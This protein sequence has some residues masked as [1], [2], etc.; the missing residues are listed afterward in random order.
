MSTHNGKRRTSGEI[1]QLI[2][3]PFLSLVAV[4]LLC[5]HWNMDMAL[6]ARLYSPESGWLYRDVPLWR[7][8]YQYG[9]L[10]GYFMVASALIS[11]YS[12]T[13]RKWKKDALFLILL[14][15]LGP[16]L[17]VNL[18]FKDHWGRPRPRQVEAFGGNRSY[19]APW[20]PTF[21]GMCSSF[22]CGHA[23]TAFFIGAPFFPLLR[24][25][26]SLARVFL[27]LGM[28]YGLLMGAAR[29]AQGG[30][31]L[32]DV[33]WAGGMVYLTGAVLYFLM[34]FNVR[35]ATEEACPQGGMA[36]PENPAEPATGVSL[37]GQLQIGDHRPVL[38]RPVRSGP[39][40]SRLQV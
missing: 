35:T 36:Y 38:R 29:M 27:A 16:G 34:G 20:E 13:R 40:F 6:A 4:T 7:C 31:F 17:L 3:F 14:L 8:L 25:S 11:N 15:C 18:V 33:I 23:S 32:T 37:K 12:V 24:R 19:H 28:V 21:D 2:V 5:L 22:P 39:A 1:I 26:R 10:P 9:T 30:H